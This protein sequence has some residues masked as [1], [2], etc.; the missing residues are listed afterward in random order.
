MHALNR[1]RKYCVVIRH[2]LIR[3][4][5]DFLMMIVMSMLMS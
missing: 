5:A 1:A 2:T 4:G 3:D